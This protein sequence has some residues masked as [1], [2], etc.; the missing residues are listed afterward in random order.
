MLP[1][2]LKAVDIDG[3]DA[4]GRTMLWKVRARA[5]AHAHAH[6]HVLVCAHTRMQARTLLCKAAGN[7]RKVVVDILVAEGASVCPLPA[8]T[9]RHID[10]HAHFHSC[11]CL[12][13]CPCSPNIRSAYR[14][15]TNTS[16]HMDTLDSTHASIALC[17]TK[18]PVGK[19][20][21]EGFRLH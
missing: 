7:G 14:T 18:M 17:G 16:T 2:L 21:F 6:A 1:I 12:G 4:H 8:Y 11:A 9:H 19:F 10:V 13:A 20:F 5:P 3:Q 15:F